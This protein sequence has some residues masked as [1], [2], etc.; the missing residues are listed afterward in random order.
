MKL[1]KLTQF[2]GE[3]DA[4]RPLYVGQH[5]ARLPPAE[6]FQTVEVRQVTGRVSLARVPLVAD[7]AR[8]RGAGD[9]RLLAEVFRSV[10][11]AG[12]R[13]LHWEVEG[14]VDEGREAALRSA[15]AVVARSLTAVAACRRRVLP[16]DDRQQ[17]TQHADAQKPS[18]TSEKTI[19]LYFGHRTQRVRPRQKL[20]GRAGGTRNEAT[21]RRCSYDTENCVH[22]QH[23]H[24]RGQ[25][26]TAQPT[27]RWTLQ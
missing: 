2:E 5:C 1:S 17:P 8:F 6:R 7:V 9:A 26:Q 19:F 23:P 3:I 15:V 10:K 12:V 25:Q 27:L 22:I 16:N 24:L 4:I 11:P 20:K 13:R 18:H 21:F 14:G